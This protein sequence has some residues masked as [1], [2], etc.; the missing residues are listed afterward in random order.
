MP[1]YFEPSIAPHM[2][3]LL[4]KKGF[5]KRKY[6]L[7]DINLSLLDWILRFILRHFVNNFWFRS[8]MSLNLRKIYYFERNALTFLLDFKNRGV[9]L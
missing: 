9:D 4:F 1:K 6:W 2:F 5:S 8:M 7:Y 3:E